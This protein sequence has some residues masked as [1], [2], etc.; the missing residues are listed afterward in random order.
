MGDMRRASLLVVCVCS[1]VA[2]YVLLAQNL[3]NE[4]AKGFGTTISGAFEGW[5]DNPDGSHS[6]LVG[7]LNRNRSKAIDVPVGPNNRIDP[8][9]PDLGQPEH[10]ETGRQWGMFVVTVPKSF[11]AR[12][13]L[14]WTITVDGQ[15]TSVPLW[16][17]TDYVIT[18]LLGGGSGGKNTPPHLRLAED[19]PPVFG[20]GAILHQSAASRTVRVG[21]KLP[22]DTWVED[23]M[24]Y[25]NDPKAPLPKNR[26]PVTLTWTKF[27]GPG[28]VT[29]E[30]AK[31]DAE[32]L[33]ASGPGFKG[34]AT[35]SAKFD[36]PGEYVLHV[37]ANDFSGSGGGGFQCCWTTALLKVSVR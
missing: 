6:F 30:H 3:P 10:F 18:P 1:I 24:E 13:R 2:S 20:P 36:T 28:D 35:T 16:M 26:A 17:H 9:G 23:D 29:F 7:Y 32:K 14:V 25:T 27:R 33:P 12:D 31:L 22:L 21:E 8:G 11:G 15:S 19:A 5:F 4:P 37:T 34:K